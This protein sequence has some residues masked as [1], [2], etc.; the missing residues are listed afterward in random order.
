MSLEANGAYTSGDPGSVSRAVTVARGDGSRVVTIPQPS[1]W[2]I[3]WRGPRPS[4]VF[5]SADRVLRV[6]G[7]VERLAPARVHPMHGGS[8]RADTLAGYTAA[9]RTLPLTFDGK[10]FGRQLPDGP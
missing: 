8:L 9:L 1:V 7:R 3:W 6:V 2:R 5:G 10:I 4:G